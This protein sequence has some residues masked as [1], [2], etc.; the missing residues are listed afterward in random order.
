MLSFWLSQRISAGDAGFQT[1]IQDLLLLGE[2]SSARLYALSH[3]GRFVANSWRLNDQGQLTL[4]SER[5]FSTD[6]TPVH[7]ELATSPT[8]G[9]LIS[10]GNP[11]NLL[12]LTL[13]SQGQ[14]SG[15]GGVSTP[16]P[17]LQAVASSALNAYALA[18][19]LDQPLRLDPQSGAPDLSLAPPLSSSDTWTKLAAIQA[20]ESTLLVS[21]SAEGG[22]RSW[23]AAGSNVSLISSY[24]PW[25]GL[26]IAAPSALEMFRSGSQILLAVAGAGSSSLSFFTVSAGGALT[27]AFHVIDSLFSRFQSVQAIA[28][29]ET[30]QGRSF[31]VAGGGDQGFSLFE[32]LPDG[33][34]LHL[35]E[36]PWSDTGH[37][38][39]LA[40]QATQT[41][42]GLRLTVVAS[43]ENGGIQVFQTE[44]S[45]ALT[46][47]RES[48]TLTGGAGAD[49]LQGTNQAS[50][51]SGGAGA[52]ILLT[53]AG[54][55]TL[56]GGAG[57]DLF[58][59]SAN[60]RVN[61]ITDY[62]PGLDHIDL[63]A[64]PMLRDPS[65]L[66]QETLSNGIR[67]TWRGTTL[68]VISATGQPLALHDLSGHLGQG[69]SLYTLRAE[70]SQPPAIPADTPDAP[71]SLTGTTG[72]D[73][74]IGAGGNDTLFG[75]LGNDELVGL[76]G[77]DDLR[78][79]PGNDTLWGDGGNDALYG[80]AGN[81]FL[82]GGLGDDLLLGGS[83]QDLLDGG[84]G[85]DR[86]EAGEGGWSTLFGGAGHDTLHAGGPFDLLDGGDGDDLLFADAPAQSGWY[87]ALL[88]QNALLDLWF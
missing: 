84:P 10:G 39:A 16:L 30:S 45:G 25:Q 71:R 21:A 61:R 76:S 35:A 44:L 83:G 50:T 70:T 12:R 33:R 19:G 14:I 86:L 9:L 5:S 11:Q 75:S 46:A 81:D 34:P 48:R 53:G 72:P 42:S 66:G 37:I 49:L 52:D 7:A 47:L 15:S 74:L 23:H 87:S 64:F 8:G 22:L 40:L 1:G 38:R 20:S 59:I 43:G 78:G 2:G 18:P 3:S 17:R 68:E 60:G 65:Q 73:L 57:A 54:A 41:A 32:V 28:V 24:T 62:T 58:V 69:P 85:N 31:L 51:L 27:P 88:S 80:E 4:V 82:S 79:G 13:G 29:A 77:H 6:Y 63:S 67:L 26:G 55:A 36:F 56:T